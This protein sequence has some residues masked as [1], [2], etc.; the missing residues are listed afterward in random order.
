MKGDTMQVAST[1]RL[2]SLTERHPFC[3]GSLERINV[4][5]LHE[6]RYAAARRWWVAGSFRKILNSKRGIFG[7]TKKNR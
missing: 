7:G 5:Y 6:K 3:T 4:E 1:N 2:L